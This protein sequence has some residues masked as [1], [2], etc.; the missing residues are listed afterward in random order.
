MNQVTHDN[1]Y[2]DINSG[3]L[4]FARQASSAISL[5][6]RHSHAR[7]QLVVAEDGV[8]DVETNS[9]RWALPAPYAL[10]IPPHCEHELLSH[11]SFNG[12]SVYISGDACSSL[13]D[14]PQVLRI[15]GL[16]RET[17]RRVSGWEDGPRG[18]AE[19][20]IVGVLLDELSVSKFET[21][22]LPMPRDERLV[23]IVEAFSQKLDDRRT[24]E[25]WA[26]WAGVS[27]RTLSRRFQ[28]ETGIS[29]SQWKQRLRLM[30][31]EEMLVCGQPVT[32]V[33]FDVGYDNV[34][35]FIAA[36]QRAYG[37]TPARYLS[38]YSRSVRK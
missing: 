31:A 27:S 18:P 29:F 4:V 17:T 16:L 25:E 8:M 10:W 37:V 33:A 1:S 15:T 21:L 34:S 28:A 3:P 14:A 12:W 32:T 20:R 26:D 23:A 36:F 5:S 11:G 35:A 13:P 22:A 38:H 9:G 6:G 19:E 30:R 2:V 24:L 7:G